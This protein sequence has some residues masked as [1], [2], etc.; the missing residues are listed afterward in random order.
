[1]ASRT[2]R[3]LALMTELARLASSNIALFVPVATYGRLKRSFRFIVNRDR[4]LIFSLYYWARWVNDG[5]GP[6]SARPGGFLV[7]FDDPKFDPRIKG[8][9]PRKPAQVKRLGQLTERQLDHV[10]FAKEVG[11]TEGLEFLQ[12]GVRKTREEA[13]AKVRELVQG[14]VRRLLRRGRNKITVRIG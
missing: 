9:Y 1:M 8:D 11:P 7:Y 2:E 5:R 13:P 14:D 3:R 10:I 12:K 6:V 4:I